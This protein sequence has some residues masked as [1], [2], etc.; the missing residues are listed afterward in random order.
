MLSE[1]QAREARALWALHCHAAPRR[2]LARTEGNHATV[3]KAE[4]RA[5]ETPVLPAAQPRGQKGLT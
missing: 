4:P 5:P 2:G 1:G 3:T